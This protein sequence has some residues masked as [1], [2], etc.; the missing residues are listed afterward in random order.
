M[1]RQLKSHP[2]IYLSDIKILKGNLSVLP[3]PKITPELDQQLALLVDRA[4]H[5]DTDAPKEIDTHIFAIYELNET[6]IDLVKL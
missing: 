2:S 5:G 4:L 3:F 6:E 1:Y